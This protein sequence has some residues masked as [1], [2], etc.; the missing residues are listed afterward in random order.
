MPI[1]VIA[2]GII[3]L[4]I[5]GCY[6]YGVI[7]TK[8]GYQLEDS[9]SGLLVF[10]AALN[11]I[12]GVILAVFFLPGDSYSRHAPDISYT[13][14]F[15]WLFEGVFVSTLLLALAEGLFYLRSINGVSAKSKK[16]KSQNSPSSG[17]ESPKKEKNPETVNLL[18]RI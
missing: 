5:F 12:G 3:F 16:E 9:T 1:L 2:V 11:L 4:I 8:P 15:T 10:L 14:S 13:L 6:G 18:K 17:H 7:N